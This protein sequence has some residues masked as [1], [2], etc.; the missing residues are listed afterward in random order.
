MIGYLMD[1]AVSEKIRKKKATSENFTHP[2]KLLEQVK[3]SLRTKHYSYRTEKSY[4]SWIKQF[5]LFH[6]KRHPKDM[7]EKE[8]SEFL[9]HLAV[10]RRVSSSTQNQA[11]CAIVF[12]YKHVLKKELGDFGDLIWAKKP[13]SIPVVLTKKEVKSILSELHGKPYLIGHLLY[14]SG[15]RLIEVLRLRVHN[16]DF[17]YNQ[18]TVIEGKGAKS[19]ITMLPETI[20]TPLKLYLQKIKK[21]HEKDL[22]NGYGSVEMP[23]ALNNKYPNADKEWKWQYVFPASRISTDPRTG[24]RRRHHLDESVFRKALKKSKNIVNINKRIS[25]HTFRHSFATHLLEE[26]YD[27]RTVQELLGHKN[28][29]TT[30]IYTHVL[31]KGGRGVISPADKL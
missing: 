25:S 22:K 31:N 8:I 7:G 29:K 27:I 5:V 12:L 16:I 18:I 4:I 19:R 28:V 21:I 14:G 23:Y 17:D 11:L 9:T 10:K 26:G 1:T 13:T 20:K 30:M 24:I 2:P 15:L 3:Q 6:G